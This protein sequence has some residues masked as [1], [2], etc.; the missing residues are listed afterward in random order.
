MKRIFALWTIL[1]L[2]C[3]LSCGALALSENSMAYDSV[4]VI[5]P[6]E[7]DLSETEALTIAQSAFLAVPGMSQETLDEMDT[8]QVF[9]TVED[10]EPEIRGWFVRFSPKGT[11]LLPDFPVDISSPEGEI[12]FVTEADYYL[13]GIEDIA[14][15]GVRGEQLAL[16]EAEKGNYHTWTLEDKIDF[17]AAYEKRD[18]AKPQAGDIPVE[19]A[20]QTAREVLLAETGLTADA[21]DALVLDVFFQSSFQPDVET[22]WYISYYDPETDEQLYVVWI[23]A[24]SGEVLD[25]TD[26]AFSNG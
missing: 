15:W 12:V 8:Y 18:G 24:Q 7:G 13:A 25:F 3:A 1:A 22:E 20:V 10:R 5:T 14:A 9:Y 11:P 17:A 4:R 16:W 23:H 21:L 19:Q 6:G 26:A 2:L